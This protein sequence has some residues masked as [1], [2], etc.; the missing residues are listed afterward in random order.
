MNLQELFEQVP[1]AQIFGDRSLPVAGLA[2][3][4]RRVSAG[5]VF[6]AI[7]GFQQDGNRFIPEALLHGALAVVSENPP[8]SLPGE[9]LAAGSSVWVQVTDVRRALALAASQFY[10]HPS[11][12]IKLVG[13]TGTNG[14][15]T[16]AFLLASVLEVA[17]WRP[18]LLGTIESRLCPGENRR[19]WSSANT[20]PESLELQKML[21]EVS[22]EGGRSTVMEVSSHALA[23]SRVAGCS[24]H[25]AVFTN[26]SRDHLDFHL[27][28]QKYFAAKEKLFLPAPEGAEPAFAVLNKD[29]P[30]AAALRART[31]SRVITYGMQSPADVTVRKWKGSRERLEFTAT[32]PAGP[33]EVCSP[34][35]GRH[36]VY[37]LLATI[38]AALT[39]DITPE[40]IARGILPVLVP[41]R[42]EAVDEGQ[43]F[44]VFVDYAHTEDALRNLLS[45]ARRLTNQGR[46]ILVFGCGGDRD[47]AKRP[48]MG[49]AAAESDWVVLTSDNPRS[50]DPIRIL[51]DIAVGLQKVKAN[52]TVEPDR[53]LAIEMALR[54]ARSG[55]TVWLAGKGHETC[56]IV[57]DQ[58]VPF[59]DREVARRVLDGLGFNSRQAMSN[60][61]SV[62]K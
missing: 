20:T 32:T 23:L 48:L 14:K 54:E 57:G 33:V 52:Y 44:R 6:F 30:R 45:S 53:A 5:E 55:D 10:G 29:D 42:F 28:E 43:P 13:I 24:F 50:E 9:E 1:E 3:H 17:G 47:R 39:L 60:K 7:H 40:S 38:A 62:G 49:M 36:N 35:Q 37:N 25:A 58:R 11:R 31:G 19:R 46:V 16:V 56:Q 21:R 4:S 34:L 26:F 27:D 8:A 59:D 51:N 15:T 12:R 61:Q 41:G 2:Y 18:G 22:E